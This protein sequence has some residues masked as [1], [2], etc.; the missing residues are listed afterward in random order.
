MKYIDAKRLRAEI[1]KLLDSVVS[2]PFIEAEVGAEERREGKIR[3][4]NEIL[5]LLDSFQQEQPEK[6]LTFDGFVDKVGAWF[7]H[8]RLDKFR[9]TFKGEIFPA[10]QL[11]QEYD[12]FVRELS[13]TYSDK[14]EQPE[15]PTTDE[16]VKEFLA[17]HPKVEVPEKYKNPDWLWKEKGQSEVDLEQE[18]IS[19]F[20]GMWPGIDSNIAMSFMPP[21]ILRLARHFYELGLNARKEE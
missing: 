3:A 12:L 7:A 9:N 15:F 18:V 6:T 21:A 17:A 16:Q 4:Y 13:K 19:Y 8:L 5:N 20:Q 14:Q 2:C 1:T 10:T 11:V